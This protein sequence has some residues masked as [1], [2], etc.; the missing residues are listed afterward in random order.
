MQLFWNQDKV[1]QAYR[2]A[3]EALNHKKVPGTDLPYI[4]HVNLVSMET[5]KGDSW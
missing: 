3:A 5:M 4:V 2:F 1:I